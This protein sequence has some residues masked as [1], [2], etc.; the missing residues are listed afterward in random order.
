LPAHIPLD[1][2]R[3]KPPADVC[4]R[5]IADNPSFGPGRFVR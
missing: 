4:F 2:E 1:A 5:T 3:R